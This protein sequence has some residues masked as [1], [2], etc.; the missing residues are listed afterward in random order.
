MPRTNRPYVTSRSSELAKL[1]VRAK[2]ARA[3]AADE[4][5]ISDGS[6][7]NVE[8][9]VARA[10]EDLLGSMARLYKVGARTVRNAYV[11]GRRA[12][13]ARDAL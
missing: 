2:L 12:L 3:A 11:Q 1:R 8:R 4:L 13:I 9:G 6:L 7:A 10:S 5:G